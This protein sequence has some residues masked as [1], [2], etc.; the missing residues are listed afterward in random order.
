MS[1]LKSKEKY[2]AFKIALVLLSILPLNAN[3]LETINNKHQRSEEKTPNLFAEKISGNTYTLGSGDKLF[4]E[5]IDLPEFSQI[6]P[7]DPT[8]Y[9][10]LPENKSLNVEGLSIEGLKAILKKEYSE[11]INSPEFNIQIVAYRP[12]IATY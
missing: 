5:F 9:I 2:N 11:V 8:G 12:V 4:I 3:A 1:L 7:I 10:Y 6:Y